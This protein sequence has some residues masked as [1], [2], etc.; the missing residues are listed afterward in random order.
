M[1]LTCPRCG[2]ANP[3]GNSFCQ[4]CGT[5]LAAIVQPASSTPAPVVGPPPDLPPPSYQSPYYTPGDGSAQPPVHRT[6]WLVIVSA[7]VGLVL[8]MGAC[9]TALAF[10][11]AR[12]ANQTSS[13]GLGSG[14]PSPTPAGT[15]SPIVQGS[16]TPVG[17]A[18][19]ASNSSLSVTVPSGWLVANK[20]SE[21]ITLVD[22]N[23]DSITIGSGPSNPSQTA[24]Q[25][26]DSLDSFFK[27]KYPD[28][29]TCPNTK[30]TTGVISGASGIL[31]TLCF[32]LTSGGQS[33]QV[34]APLFAGA[35]SDGSVYYAVVL[36]SPVSTMNEFIAASKPVL[37]SIQWALK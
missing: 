9:G 18:G 21:T 8:V 6:P 34:G 17:G 19:K 20:D 25:N 36:F 13:T 5:Q 30:V 28:T 32:T 37:A 4:A 26:K 15:P 1:A 3:D 24:Q 31:W 35:N 2:A 23:G 33:V 22:S 29:K 10:F 11:N 27:G 14:L 16:P 7:V 12:N